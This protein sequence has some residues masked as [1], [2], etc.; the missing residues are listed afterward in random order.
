MAPGEQVPSSIADAEAVDQEL[1]DEVDLAALGHGQAL[2]RKFDIWSILALAFC[3]LGTWSTFA[4]VRRRKQSRSRDDIKALTSFPVFLVGPFKRT[5]QWRARQHPLGPRPRHPLQRLRCRLPRRALQQ[6]AYGPGPS[7]L[8]P[9][10]LEHAHGPLRLVPLRLD[11]HVWVVDAH[12][13]AGRLHDQL[14]PEHEA[15]VRPGVDRWERA[16]GAVPGLSW[17]HSPLHRV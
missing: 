13:L 15:H 7:L 17:H 16:V 6:H 9:P 4:Q 11:Q 10:P 5:Y 3:V 2:S 8:G 14:C 1:I 12:G